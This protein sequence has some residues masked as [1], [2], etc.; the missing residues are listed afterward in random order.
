MADGGR[1][2]TGSITGLE[3]TSRGTRGA[4][5]ERLSL[6]VLDGSGEVRDKAHLERN[7]QWFKFK[8]ETQERV[9]HQAVSGNA[10]RNMANPEV[11]D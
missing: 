1:W 6:R 7:L 4:R 5:R 2:V 11:T 3:S 8:K 10:V 9:S